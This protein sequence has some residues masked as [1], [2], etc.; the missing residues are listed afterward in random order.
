LCTLRLWLGL[1]PLGSGGEE[2]VITVCLFRFSHLVIT[3]C[4][5]SPVS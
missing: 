1:R 5:Q 4:E 2:V 3:P